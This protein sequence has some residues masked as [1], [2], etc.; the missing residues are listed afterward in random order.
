MIEVTPEGWHVIAGDQYLSKWVRESGK[1]EVEDACLGHELDKIAKYISKGSC[2]ID[3]G[4]NIG[5]WSA[6]LLPLVGKGGLVVS[7][8]ADSEAC[9]CTR[10]NLEFQ[11]TRNGDCGACLVLNN[12]ISDSV[13][14]SVFFCDLDNRG[15]SSVYED[16]V[17][18][19]F[20]TA[21]IP[22]KR[23]DD[24]DTDGRRIDLIKID[25]EGSEMAALRSG[26]NIINEHRPVMFIEIRETYKEMIGW[27][28]SNDY[29]YLLTPEEWIRN[30]SPPHDLLCIPFE[31]LWK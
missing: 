16:K 18:G 10:R 2:A 21:I 30:G 15:G 3:I 6:P 1:M 26:V 4:C 7:V 20:I 28:T 9:E 8:D 31:K 14:D 13:G 17:N 12:A 5:T 11:K 29:A 22:N 25:C 27:L 24:I 23:L 19:N